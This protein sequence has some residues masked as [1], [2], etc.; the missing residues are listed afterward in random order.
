MSVIHEA[1]AR[2]DLDPAELD[3]LLDKRPKAVKERAKPSGDLPLH[4]ALVAG[5]AAGVVQTLLLRWPGAAKE[6]N[7]EKQLPLHVAAASKPNSSLS[8]ETLALLLGSHP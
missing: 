2:A 8:S 1:V 7:K 3:R 4:A 5:G 6:R